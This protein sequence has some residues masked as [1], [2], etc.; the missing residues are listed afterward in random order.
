MRIVIVGASS[1]GLAIAEQLI[2]IDKEVVLIDKSRDLLEQAAEQIDCGMIEGGGTSPDVLREAFRSEEDVCIAVTDASEINIL[3][4]LIARSIG[5]CRVIPQITS[6]DLLRVCHELGLDDV[7]NPHARVAEDIV[8]AL[9]QGGD[10]S[11]QPL[12]QDSLALTRVTV[13]EQ[14]AQQDLDLPGEGRVVALIRDGE[15][16]L[17]EQNA[18]FQEGDI[19]VVL[20]KRDAL[21]DLEDLFAPE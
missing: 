19:L 20:L 17:P 8:E 16:F 1:F 11:Q 14:L 7:I 10:P 4:A 5:Y 21:G 12:L 9:T 6:N 18:S 2:G 13:P 15:E 3:S